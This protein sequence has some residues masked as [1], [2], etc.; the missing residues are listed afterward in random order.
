MRRPHPATRAFALLALC[1]VPVAASCG[2]T[3]ILESRRPLNVE[4]SVDRAE[5]VVNSE[6]AVQVEAVG[7]RLSEVVISFGDGERYVHT[8]FGAIDLRLKRNHAYTVPGQYRI[9]AT[10]Q[11]ESGE[12]VSDDLL[13][14][15]RQ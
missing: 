5:A 14:M 6:L 9:E 12:I 11:L 15:V 7:A 2:P 1:Y 4:V 8:A 10:A 3:G 13:V